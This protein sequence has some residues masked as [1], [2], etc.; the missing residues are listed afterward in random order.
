M[1]HMNS[2]GGLDTPFFSTL[3]SGPFSSI[4]SSISHKIS[5]CILRDLLVVAVAVANGVVIA[6][7]AAVVANA[8]AVA[9]L[10]AVAVIDGFF[11]ITIHHSCSHALVFYYH[12][13]P[14][15]FCVVL[16]LVQK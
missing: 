4:P 15:G 11:G 7:F 16:R 1:L 9:C 2:I 8:S 6:S 14:I 12:S 13:L 5:W 10:T 3:T